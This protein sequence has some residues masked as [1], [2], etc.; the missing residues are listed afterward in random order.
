[1]DFKNDCNLGYAFINFVDRDASDSF[2][3]RVHGSK[4]TQ[5]KSNKVCAVCHATIQGRDALIERFRNSS[6]MLEQAAYRPKLFYTRGPLAGQEEP[7]P[8]PNASY[9][10]K[11]DV[12]FSR[13]NIR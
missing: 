11:V 12:L 6:V 4:W 13:V 7:F 8:P 2:K 3:Q 5:F 1:M 9:R 10:P